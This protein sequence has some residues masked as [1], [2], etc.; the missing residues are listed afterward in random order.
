VADSLLDRLDSPPLRKALR[1]NDEDTLLHVVTCLMALDRPTPDQQLFLDRLEVACRKDGG[2]SLA[3]YEML[4]SRARDLRARYLD[5]QATEDARELLD[6]VV[7]EA[8]DRY[9]AENDP[10]ADVFEALLDPE[11]GPPA[12]TPAS[13]FR[14]WARRWSR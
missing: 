9:I 10:M 4:R 3:E 12:P 11:D 1:F 14:K 13:G 5:E 8:A 7:K 2:A 6:G